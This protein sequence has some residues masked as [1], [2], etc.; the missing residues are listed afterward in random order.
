MSGAINTILSI[1]TGVIADR[2]GIKKTLIL[3]TLVSIAGTFLFSISY[4]WTIGALAL[5]LTTVGFNLNFT[6]CPMICGSVVK[7]NER[8]T[9]MGICDTI[10]FIPFLIGPIIAASLITYFGGMN[11]TGIR[12]LFYFQLAGL[13]LSLV[14]IITRFA[15]PVISK[16]SSELHI[17]DT[18]KGIMSENRSM[19]SWIVL[20]FLSNFPYFVAFYTPLFAAEVKGANQFI[21][22]GMSSAS[23][24]VSIVLAVPIGHLA[25]KIGRR[26]IFKV[27]TLL[28]CLSYFFLIFAESQMFLIISGLLSGFVMP[29]L[30]ILTAVSFDLV[31]KENLGSWIGFL[32][33][34]SGLSN[35][36]APVFCGYLWDNINAQSVF[37]FLILIRMLSLVTLYAIP[38]SIM[39]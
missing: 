37:Y 1:P 2:I 13:I 4:N 18:L 10:T 30:V 9:V 12:P 33:F 15:N 16:S 27:S 17:I 7:S 19:I 25:D 6:V 24:L 28:S 22:G 32:G 36:L 26:S 20:Y 3:T 29:M 34:I 21:I 8:V 35:I 23:M 39:K 14:L 11:A 38:K 31:S 5:I